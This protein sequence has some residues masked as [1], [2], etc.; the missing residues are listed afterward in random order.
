[1]FIHTHTYVSTAAC[2]PSYTVF[3]VYRTSKWNEKKHLA[4]PT[5]SELAVYLLGQQ[6]CQ[7]A[8]FPEPSCKIETKNVRPVACYNCEFLFKKYTFFCKIWSTTQKRRI[9]KYKRNGNL[10]ECSN[11]EAWKYRML[12]WW[13]GKVAV[14]SNHCTQV[15][16]HTLRTVNT[17]A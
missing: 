2:Q 16:G 8:L 13:L 17:L 12:H 1:M 14:N 10:M 4:T 7:Q 6:Y 9:T 5:T 3:T 11:T 15:Q